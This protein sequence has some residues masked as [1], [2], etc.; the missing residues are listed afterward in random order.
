M[1]V[2]GRAGLISCSFQLQLN[3]KSHKDTLVHASVSFYYV[4]NY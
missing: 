3:T 1:I 4:K 2:V